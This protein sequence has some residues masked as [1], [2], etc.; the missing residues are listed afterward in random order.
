[1]TKVSSGL[2]AVFKKHTHFVVF[3]AVFIA[4][5]VVRAAVE[6]AS[7]D[8]AWSWSG[9]RSADLAGIVTYRQFAFANNHLLTSLWIAL[10]QWAGS[11][12]L[13]P[14]RLPSLV[15]APLFVVGLYRL[16]GEPDW[17][18]FR[19]A[20]LVIIALHPVVFRSFALARGY[21]LAM[22]AMA[23][24]LV[25]AVRFTR[26]HRRRDLV[27]CLAC[28]T[29]AALAIF[30]FVYF[31]AALT[32]L[33]C[34]YQLWLYRPDIAGGRVGRLAKKGVFVPELGV[35]L[36]TLLY[37]YPVGQRVADFDPNIP[38]ASSFVSGTGASMLSDIVGIHVWPR[39]IRGV[40]KLSITACALVI[41]AGAL[42][43]VVRRS[44]KPGR[45]VLLCWA[46]V[47]GESL[48]M[49]AVHFVT[50]VPF[51]MGRTVIFLAV[52][53]LLVLA[54]ILH[55]I[56][57]RAWPVAGAGLMILLGGSSLVIDGRNVRNA[58]HSVPRATCVYLG[59]QGGFGRG[60]VE[61]LHESANPAWRYYRHV[62]G[63]ET[64]RLTSIERAPLALE[65]VAS[66]DYLVVSAERA[67]ELA[68]EHTR[69]PFVQR[70]R[71]PVQ[72]KVLLERRARS[73]KR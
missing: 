26:G 18:D 22:T 48:T 1:M 17:R 40:L 31:L 55:Q 34:F 28:G 64:V 21:A 65:E 29:V 69:W 42:W 33:S 73:G 41:A 53:L 51:P 14:M 20:G 13:F 36:I 68:S 15:M 60:E 12:S 54:V 61:L 3:C 27:A 23:W 30:S 57:G 52:Q 7:Y 67:E 59:Q 5:L 8:E 11:D 35:L 44:L 47:A 6:G 25:L 16:L 9:V 56:P 72:G 71:F 43:C 37:L 50:G 58:V 70:R 62:S 63:L 19:F 45:A 38:G 24:A 49:Y 66:F 4:A 46:L 2:R 32:A 10:L 39:L